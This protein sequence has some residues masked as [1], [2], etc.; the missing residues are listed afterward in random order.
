MFVY[1]DP[2]D[3]CPMG[4]RWAAANAAHEDYVVLKV[5]PGYR[6]C[7]SQPDGWHQYSPALRETS[8]SGYSFS[9]SPGF[10][11]YGEPTP[12]LERDPA[13]WSQNIRDMIASGA[14][15]QLV[16]TFSE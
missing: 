15:W 10:F 14:P 1:A 5:F 11:K 2:N 16:I 12:R 3:S 9:I 4:D 8:Q 7:A 13:A 6:A